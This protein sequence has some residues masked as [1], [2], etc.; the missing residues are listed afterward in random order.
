MFIS[1]QQAIRKVRNQ[2]NGSNQKTNPQHGSALRYKKTSCIIISNSVEK[3]R[4]RVMSEK[5]SEEPLLH[6]ENFDEATGA[7]S[8]LLQSKHRRKNKTDMP[9]AA[10]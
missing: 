6:S 10:L 4:E 9:F 1:C 8:S 3:M 5:S 7:N 2:P